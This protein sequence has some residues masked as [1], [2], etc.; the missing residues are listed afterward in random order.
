LD[1]NTRQL[2][3]S[4]SSWVKSARLETPFVFLLEAHRP[5][6]RLLGHSLIVLEPVA[7]GFVGFEKIENLR[8]LLFDPDAVDVMVEKLKEDPDNDSSS[9]K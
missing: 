8:K 4:V 5:I 2:A 9:G 6:L 1:D 3:E 7:A